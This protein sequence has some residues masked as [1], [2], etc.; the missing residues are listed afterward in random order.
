VLPIGPL[1]GPAAYAQLVESD[2]RVVA[3]AG[4]GARLPATEEA[5]AI[6]AGERPAGFTEA[7]LSSGHVRVYTAPVAPGQA[8]QVARSLD[9]TDVT[10]DRLALILAAVSL[11]GV[12]LGG[13]FGLLIS[14]AAL[15][16]V[17]R[18][19]RA[20]SEVATTRDLSHR[21]DPAGGHELAELA[22][23]FNRMLTALE[24]SLDSQRQL[25]ADASHELR[26]PLASLRT[27]IEVLAHSESMDAGERERLLAD[28]IGQLDELTALVGDLVDLARDAE[29]D[30]PVEL[31]RLDRLTEEAVELARSRTPSARIE[32]SAEPCPVRGSEH[33]LTRAVS[34]LLDNAIKW[35]PR[36]AP[37]EVT[38]SADGALEVRDR[39]PGIAPDDAPRVFDRFY[40]SAAARGMPGSGLGLAIVRQVAESHG[41]FA[42]AVSPQGGGT[43]I[44]VWVPVASADREPA[45]T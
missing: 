42:E 1:G 36:D 4:L 41:G 2:G 13:A 37:I 33:A 8:I 38:V 22:R 3:P 34:N 17:G 21:I 40:R 19:S 20:A 32:L 35:S 29:L 23:S 11:G 27:N 5:I 9:E 45:L 14:R 28:V 6:A 18:L 12:V 44:R 25:V 15:S 10:L 31:L 43:L 30:E 26:T 39:G 16:P 24:G 7:Q